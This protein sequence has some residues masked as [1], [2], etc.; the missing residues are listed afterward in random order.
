MNETK[1][2]AAAFPHGTP[3]GYAL[4]CRGVLS[5]AFH[6]TPIRTCVE[7]SRMFAGDWTYRRRVQ[8]GMTP[9]AIHAAEQEDAGRA[10]PDPI[11]RQQRPTPTPVFSDAQEGRARKRAE[12]AAAGTPA[13][14]RPEPAAP[15]RGGRKPTPIRHGTNQGYAK[16]CHKDSPCPESPTCTEVHAERMRERLRKKRGDAVANPVVTRIDE[17]T[18]HLSRGGEYTLA[19]LFPEVAA[20]LDELEARP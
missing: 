15:N 9:E 2:A 16:G 12:A 5:C 4:G 10:T 6:G 13:P 17:R 19:K 14:A 11:F 1:L 18:V 8:A 20:R 3:E 7:A